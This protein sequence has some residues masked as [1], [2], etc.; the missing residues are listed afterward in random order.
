[1]KN[2]I[3]WLK[4]D[5]QSSWVPDFLEDKA[6]ANLWESDFYRPFFGKGKFFSPT[7]DIH[8]GEKNIT[9]KVE[10]PGV[11][12]KDISVTFQDGYASITG[13][14]KDEHCDK[15][16]AK[17]SYECSYGYFSRKFY[18]GSQEQIDW[19]NAKANYKKGV[20]TLDIPKKKQETKN[21]KIKV[22]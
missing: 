12:E 20:L 18:V 21:I 5:K 15:K 19:N 14:K 8:E 13:E 6:I 17:G 1:M 9:A 16:N 4:R 7:V 22:E 11:D 2:I 3:P 10:I